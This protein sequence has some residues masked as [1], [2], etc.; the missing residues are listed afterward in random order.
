MPEFYHEAGTPTSQ[1]LTTSRQASML[2][3]QQEGTERK[4]DMGKTP[5]PELG[6]KQALHV[7]VRLR[8]FQTPSTHQPGHSAHTAQRRS[9]VLPHT[10]LPASPRQCCAAPRPSRRAPSQAL[11]AAIPPGAYSWLC[12]SAEAAAH[13]NASRI[14]TSTPNRRPAMRPCTPPSTAYPL[15]KQAAPVQPYLPSTVTAISSPT[16]RVS[17]TPLRS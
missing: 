14:R 9:L 4:N 8:R 15:Q 1:V 6:A 5:A 10:P 17:H 2:T 11:R 3:D 7:A 12:S 13:P 16:R